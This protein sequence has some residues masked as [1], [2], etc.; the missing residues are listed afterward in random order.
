MAKFYSRTL[1]PRPSSTYET[2]ETTKEAIQPFKKIRYKE[3][4]R[5]GPRQQ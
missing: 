1:N 2:K 4:F 5:F 3:N